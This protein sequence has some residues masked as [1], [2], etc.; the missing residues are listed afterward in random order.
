MPACSVR[1]EAQ[2]EPPAATPNPTGP[3]P[4]IAAPPAAPHID[5][6]SDPATPSAAEPLPTTDGH[7]AAQP[8]GAAPE[9]FACIPGG[10]FIRGYNLDEH[11]CEQAGNDNAGRPSARPEARIWLDTFYMALHETTNAQ[12]AAC[13]EAGACQEAGPRYSDFDRDEQPI[14]GVSWFDARDYCQFVGGH[15]PT[16]AEWEKAARGEDG[17]IFPWG[18]EPVDCARAVIMDESGRSCGVQKRGNHPETGRVLEVGSRPAGRYGLFDMAGNAE[19]W[20][21]DWYAP[22]YDACGADCLGDNPRG[23]CSGTE[24]CDGFRQRVVRGGSW[25]WPGEHTTGFH[26]R[27]HLPSNEYFHHFG[28]RCAYSM[29][30]WDARSAEGSGVR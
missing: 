14:T 9:G 28:F 8:C 3:A 10:Y 25:Y 16:E 27:R 11:D 2:S 12:Y 21:A 20:V 30:E 1:V 18:N 13:L 7:A 26:R 17:E 22:D 29:Q 24:D 19:E 23:P 15:L 5:E 6:G 4:T